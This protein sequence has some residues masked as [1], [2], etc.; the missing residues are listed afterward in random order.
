MPDNIITKKKKKYTIY[1]TRC[2][3]FAFFY[4]LFLCK[5][6]CTYKS[7]GKVTE[8]QYLSVGRSGASCGVLMVVYI[9]IG[10]HAAAWV[11]ET[12]E[13]ESSITLNV[14][15]AFIS[16]VSSGLLQCLMYCGDDQQMA[17]LCV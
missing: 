10:G 13:T 2:S 12:L 4:F 11:V 6:Y 5:T 16:V 3:Y 17:V 7:G 9:H 1:P 14:M 15:D 8:K